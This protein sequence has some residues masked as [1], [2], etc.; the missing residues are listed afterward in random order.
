MARNSSTR[1]GSR[2]TRNKSTADSV[3]AEPVT[4]AET[5]AA[6]A[7]GDL[8]G[9]TVLVGDESLGEDAVAADPDPGERVTIEPGD[10]SSAQGDS[11]DPATTEIVDETVAATEPEAEER[12]E[13]GPA[14]VPVAPAPVVERRGPGI[15]PLIFG[16]AVAAM[17]GYG[18]AYLA[19]GTEETTPD[20][21]LAEALTAIEA[22]QATITSL[23]EQI[24]ALAA[25]EPPAIPEV[26]LSGVEESV[27]AAAADAAAANETATAA[28]AAIEGLTGRVAALEDR[29][30]FSGEVD[31]DNAAMAAAV[32]ALEARLG[33]ERAA[34]AEVM[35]EAEAAREAAEAEVRAAAAE[36]QAAAEAAQA[37]IVAA[38][39][40]AAETAA[41]TQ[42]QA[43]LARVRIAMASGDPFADALSDL[44]GD[45]PEALSAVA[46]T[47]VPTQEEL[48]A[49]FPAAARAALPIA[50]RETAGDSAGDRVGAF[51]MG[52]LGGRSVEPREG[53]DPDAVL[54]RAEAAAAAGDLQTALA[55]IEALPEGAQAAFADWVQAAETRAAADAALAE[56]AATLDN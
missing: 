38:E 10:T 4:D 11:D 47:G 9:D 37:A 23:E 13:P 5:I 1:S 15:V 39:A 3:A 48:Q 40:R 33:E 45:V 56:Y 42:A 6:D 26:D 20:P 8:G 52:Q 44:G 14:P 54:S 36:A 18:A 49:S 31:E 17:L 24:A 35:A 21:A 22:Q 34:A 29:P 19:T 30:V 7:P 16:G 27:A 53:D 28:T 32:E 55:E 41:A 50:L 25:E 12:P 43:A 46:E 2:K 51:L